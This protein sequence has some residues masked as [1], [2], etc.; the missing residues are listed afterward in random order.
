MPTLLWLRL[1]LV[2]VAVALFV[3]ATAYVLIA[4]V[5]VVFGTSLILLLWQWLAKFWLFVLK[6]LKFL[7]RFGLRWLPNVAKRFVFRKGM[8]GISKIVTTGV[9]AGIFWVV[10]GERYRRYA[11]LLNR[12][13]STTV[14]WL[15][16]AWATE[17]WFFPKWLRAVVFVVAAVACVIAFA[18]IQEWAD[19]RNT[20]TF[21]GIDPW[22]F[23]FGL[24]AS[25]F[26]TNL[27]LMGFDHFL[28]QIFRPLQRHYRRIIRR[29]GL[30]YVVLNWLMAL[31]PA[32]RRAELERKRFMRRWHANF[33]ARRKEAAARHRPVE[34]PLEP[35]RPSPDA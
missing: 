2:R 34:R 17:L 7:A 21:Y 22:S 4:T 32:R 1:A 31:R 29:R 27:P 28:N 10:G 35:P 18:Q 30:L 24:I 14:R 6:W 5:D 15:K 8:S 9:L 23:L 16:A 25:F 12:S 19:N 20:P 33:N 26:L 3:A 11:E 13:K